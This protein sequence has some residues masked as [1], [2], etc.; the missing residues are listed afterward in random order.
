M[1]NRIEENW[2]KIESIESRVREKT[3]D[4]K[5]GFNA[6]IF[7]FGNEGRH[8][9][10][11][12]MYRSKKGK[13]GQEEFSKSYKEMLVYA[14]FCPFSGKPLYED[15]PNPINLIREKVEDL[16]AKEE[17]EEAEYLKKM[18]QKAYELGLEDSSI[19]TREIEIDKLLIRLKNT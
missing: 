6:S 3:G 9:G 12:C 19:P 18:I 7:W 13:K 11:P 2:Q 5:A 4:P 15:V 8:L 10:I 1:E 17:K 14:K 16:R